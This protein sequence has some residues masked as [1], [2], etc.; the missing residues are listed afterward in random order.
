MSTLH[1]PRLVLEPM[2][3]EHLDDLD[4]M[5]ADPEV[6]RY[7]KGHGVSRE[8]TLAMIERVQQRWAEFGFSWWSFVE[9]DSGR[10]IGA[11]CVQHLNRDRNNPLETGWRL[12]RDRWGLGYASEAARHMAA[13]AFDTLNA[14]LL[15]AVCQ[16]DNLASAHVMQKLGMQ[17]GP[18]GHFYDMECRYFAMTQAQW[19][20]SVKA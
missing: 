16:P 1:T 2:R 9:R 18:R 12:R 19:R 10:V 17:E 14:P 4:A 6:M 11:G 8:E 20:D 7:I 5:N 15:T 13:F 3:L